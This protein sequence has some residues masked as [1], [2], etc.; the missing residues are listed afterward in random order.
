M[1]SISE[2]KELLM[3]LTQKVIALSEQV[4]D[5]N[6]DRLLDAKGL[7]SIGI[8][9]AAAY[10][11]FNRADFPTIIIGRRKFVRRSKLYAFLDE[12]G[13]QLEY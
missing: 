8:P 7:I 12:K 11:L 3:E 5:N 9:R 13:K 4:S 1:E 2:V 10:N 6:Q